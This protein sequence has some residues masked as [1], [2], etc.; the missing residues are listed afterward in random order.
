MIRTNQQPPRPFQQP[1][2]VPPQQAHPRQQTNMSQLNAQQNQSQNQQPPPPAPPAPL[3]TQPVPPNDPFVTAKLNEKLLPFSLF[4]AVLDVPFPGASTA[5]PVELIFP[6]SDVSS[7]VVDALSL[8]DL[9]KEF[10]EENGSG[11]QGGAKVS[12]FAFPDYED[13]AYAQEFA[14][15]QEYKSRFPGGPEHNRYDAYLEETLSTMNA[16]G[17]VSN[18]YNSANANSPNSNSPKLPSYHTFSHRLANGMTVHCHVRKYLP[19]HTKA[20]GRLDVGRRCVRALVLIT[21]NAGGGNRLYMALLKALEVLTLEAG[22]LSQDVC[23]RG[24]EKKEETDDVAMNSSMDASTGIRY[25]RHFLHAAY[26]EHMNLCREVAAALA[27]GAKSVLAK[28]R[29]LTLPLAEVGTGHGLFGAVDTLRL[30]VPSSFLH[31]REPTVSGS[32]SIAALSRNDMLPMLRC[33]GVTRTMRLLSALMSERR[34]IF[35]S[36]NV[37]KLAAVGYGA[38]AMMGQGLLPPPPVFVPVLPPGLASLL[39]TPSPYLIGVLT[40]PTPHFINLRNVPNIGEVVLFDLDT[41]GNEPFFAGIPNPQQA[42]PDLTRRNLDEFDSANRV[43]L[44]DILYQDLTEVMKLDKR[45]FWQGAV[46]EKLGLAAERGRTAAKNAMKKGLQ[47]F[48]NKSKEMKAKESF[49]TDNVEDEEVEEEAATSSYSGENA[50]SK[51]VGKGNYFFE[52]GFCHEAAE[53]EARVAFTTFFV[54]ILGDL[55]TYLT[56]QTPGTSPVVDKEKFMR[57]R[58]SS[59]DTPG[60]AMFLLCG[61]F[62]RGKIFDSF[63]EARMLEVQLRRTVPEDAPIFALTTNFHR[64]N[65][66]DFYVNNVRNSVRQVASDADFPGR[67]LISWNEGVRRRVTELTSAQAFNGDP[68][69]ALSLLTEDCRES[70]VI[71]IDAV[72]VLWTRIL[73]GKGMQWKKALLALQMFRNLI[74]NGPIN[75]ISEAIDGFASIRTLR[76]YT[77]ALRGQNSALIREAASEIYSLIVDLPVLFARRRQFLN[78]RRLERDPKP[79]PLRK[80]TRMVRGINQFRNVHIALRPAGASVAPAPPAVDDLLAR[81]TPNTTASAPP[82]RGFSEDLLAMGDSST[83]TP[84]HFAGGGEQSSANPF[85]MTTLSQAIPSNNY[86]ALSNSAPVPTTFP[87]QQQG[88]YQS[89]QKTHPIQ[90]QQ[91]SMPQTQPSQHHTQQPPQ[92]QSSATIS[93]T[94]QQIHT[95]PNQLSISHQTQPSMPQPSPYISSSMHRIQTDPQARQTSIPAPETQPMQQYTGLQN[96]NPQY[97]QPPHLINSSSPMNN[98]VHRAQGQFHTS[99]AASVPTAPNMNTQ[100]RIPLPYGG[101]HPL[102]QMQSPH[103]HNQLMPGIQPT[104]HTLQNGGPTY[105]NTPQRPFG[106]STG[107][108]GPATGLSPAGFQMM[109]SSQHFQQGGMQHLTNNQFIQQPRASNP[110]QVGGIQ[111]PGQQQQSMPKPA[112]SNF[113]PLAR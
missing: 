84:H 105:Q 90:I 37:S 69:K 1:Q 91:P 19:Y 48:K 80:E 3:T 50:L 103:H 31:E 71:L 77:E 36:A 14:L 20:E 46:Q 24:D 108:N 4:D 75:A 11:G 89:D 34:I 32:E 113:D 96:Q 16:S 61:N 68:V 64:S 81:E 93:Q 74:L 98:I 73:E 26:K 112:Y 10:G 85:D 102:P 97:S 38:V 92:G 39:Q 63:V 55:R 65:K 110:N 66:V 40:G 79:S 100:S 95:Q 70:S 109:Q 106:Q 111:Q 72:M 5:S 54:C 107:T 25:R 57:F 42:V 58:N 52:Q 43:S 6:P 88:T 17:N 8:E 28:P 9:K 22:A 27:S 47:Y 82:P 56:Q 51:S 99:N 94:S 45:M 44:P 101:G 78:T 86:D 15:R 7:G 29:I 62:V 49:G 83:S 87:T 33:L 67:H 23:C 21:R 12:R 35:T 60:T 2:Q 13:R 18:T 59:G 76:S 53:L 30:A 104:P 41:S